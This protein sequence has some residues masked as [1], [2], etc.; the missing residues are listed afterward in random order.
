[1]KFI[2][3]FDFLIED[4]LYSIQEKLGI[5][6][7]WIL[8]DRQSMVYV[9]SNPRLLTNIKEVKQTCDLH[10]NAGKAVVTM[11][12]DRAPNGM[13]LP[14]RNCQHTVS[15]LTTEEIQVDI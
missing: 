1:M 3:G 5:P 9:F 15:V 8:F 2:Q 12:G 6:V 4:I 7:S 11:K 13:L 10:C 14:T